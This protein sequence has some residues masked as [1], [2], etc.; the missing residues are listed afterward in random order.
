MPTATP[1]LN[2]DSAAS[3]LNCSN[4]SVSADVCAAAPSGV[5]SISNRAKTSYYD[6]LKS[7]ALIGGS[8]LANI[9]IGIVRT[10]MMA[11]LL[12]PAGFGLFGLY[13]LVQNLA[14][15]IG[16]M[17]VN[18][19]G[20][21]QIAASAGSGNMQRIAETA[22]VLRRTS[23]ALGL[24]GAASL[25]TLSRQA[26]KVTF[27]DTSHTMAISFLSIAVFFG[28]VSGGQGALLQGMR[29]IADLARMNILAALFGL[30]VAIPLVYFF[31]QRGVVPSIVAVA[32]MS[33][34]SSWWY[35]RKLEIQAAD[36]SLAQFR[37]E[38]FALLKLGAAF[39]ASGLLTLGVAYVVRIMILRDLGLPA[40]GLYQ[41]AWTLGGL[42]VAFIL[43]A[44]AA[45]FYPRLTATIDRHLEANRLVNEQILIGLLFAG[46]GVIAALTFAPIAIALFY[47]SKFGPAVSLLRWICLGAML[48]V[49][50]WPMGFIVVAKARQVLFFLS[51]LLWSLVAIATTWVGIHQYGLD[52]AGIA[53]FGSYIFHVLISFMFASRLS[54]YYPSRKIRT[55]GSA[56]FA[57]VALTFCSFY[58]LSSVSALCI[59]IIGTLA[60]TLYSLRELLIVLGEP[61]LAR[62]SRRFLARFGLRTPCSE[63]Q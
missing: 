43:Q 23:V 16:G 33:I 21:R 41:A 58:F 38:A 14:Q 5:D 15:S 59:G 36:I 37:H 39:M 27:G 60:S 3:H 32:G 49:V 42:Y 28:L 29:R 26:S 12:G 4:T 46:P 55:V 61:D 63:S 54:G 2:R 7:S 53:F 25:L 52:G 48:Q 24:L 45:D 11:M 20:V 56:L 50:S 62:L 44:M 10:K 30:C 57:L 13:G 9:A 6:I 47:S 1:H 18:S 22:T 19:S 34:L 8:Q 31:R 17:G 51:E 40:T 35:S